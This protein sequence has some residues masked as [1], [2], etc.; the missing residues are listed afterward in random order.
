MYIGESSCFPPALDLLVPGRAARGRE[1]ASEP[2]S[3]P[4]HLQ[5]QWF[6]RGGF[7]GRD[8]E[9]HVGQMPSCVVE[10]VGWRAEHGPSRPP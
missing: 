4:N 9:G 5:K 1:G 2:V 8:K 6:A 7:L 3:Q 10:Q